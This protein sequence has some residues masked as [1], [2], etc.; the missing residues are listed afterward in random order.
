MKQR[1]FQTG[2]FKPVIMLTHRTMNPTR[3]N[4][5]ALLLSLII[6]L[7]SA[8][9]TVAH[10]TEAINTT[11]ESK[12]K[13]SGLT[14]QLLYQYLI[15]EIAGQR[16]RSGLALRGMIDL[17]QRTRDPRLARR[18]VEIAFQARQTD[19]ALEATT[20]WLEL[21]PQSLVARQAMT[22]ITSNQGTLE[23]TKLDLARLLAQP[24]STAGVLM[25]LSVILSRFP[26]KTVVSGV[27]RELAGPYLK[28][29]EAHFAIAKSSMIAKDSEAALLAI[30][31]AAKLRPGWDQA[32]ILKSQILREKSD[33]SAGSFLKQFLVTYPDAVSV[34]VTYARLLA[35]QKG[36]LQAREEFRV[37]MKSKPEDAEIPYAIGLLSQQIEDYTD[38]DMQ[39]KRVIDLKPGDASPVFFNLGVVSEAKKQPADAID[40]YGK[41]KSGDYFVTA[42][43]KIAG[44]LLRRD[45]MPAGR[46]FLQEA[47]AGQ[48]DSPETRTQLILAEA[49]LM[50]DAK[51]FNDAFDALSVAIIKH[52]DTADLF[53]DRAMVA[54]KIEKLDVMESDLRKV[55]ELKP[56]H[57]QAYNALGYTFAERNKRLDEAYELVKKAVSLS[58]DDAFI[59]DSLGWV[60]YRTGRLDEALA[61]L[62]KAYQSRRD[63][64]IA[65][66]LGEVLWVKGEH[67][68]A[69]KLWQAAL[70]D[71]PENDLLKTVI[72]K[73]KP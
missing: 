64:E 41:I 12:A 45:G 24:K 30:N 72:G 52:P 68:E 58:P 48:T 47:Q 2:I 73:F 33:D 28:F 29:P 35:A 22:A 5:V 61:T 53:Y 54:E 13:D 16:G 26:D 14:D 1:P 23:T 32:A 57:A 20:L 38:A 27:V 42:Q 19:V 39:F 31:E 50:R 51:A 37:A 11:V 15:S 66:H 46:K 36:Y 59:Q 67:A 6:L 25:Q 49:Q 65:A 44:I 70:L 4:S 18:A 9:Q 10:P 69:L 43:L 21:E 62:R 34:R 40:W 3:Q 60:L 63:P 8:G 17:A 7:S 55:I 71:N 56:D